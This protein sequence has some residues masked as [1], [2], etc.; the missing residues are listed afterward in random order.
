MLMKENIRL[1]E[2]TLCVNLWRLAGAIPLKHHGFVLTLGNH[3]G[4]LSLDFTRMG[5]VWDVDDD[6]PGL[7]DSICMAK[8]YKIDADPRLLKQYCQDTKPFNWSS[9]NCQTWA[10]GLLTLVGVYDKKGRQRRNT[11]A[12]LLKLEAHPKEMKVSTNRKNE[13][14]VCPTC[15]SE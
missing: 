11:D 3:C 1:T 8:T 13:R 5:L 2:I 14:T 6:F 7:D 4:F 10:A 15:L 9:N 12:D